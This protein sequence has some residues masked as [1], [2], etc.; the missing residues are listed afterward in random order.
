[1]TDAVKKL[2]DLVVECNQRYE[3]FGNGDT[4]A[5]TYLI[6]AAYAWIALSVESLIPELEADMAALKEQVK[7][8]NRKWIERCTR[9]RAKDAR[10]AEE[11]ER[12]AVAAALLPVAREM[13]IEMNGSGLRPDGY[14][15]CRHYGFDDCTSP[16][17][18]KART[19]RSA[20]DVHDAEA[21]DRERENICRWLESDPNWP[22]GKIAAR[23]LREMAVEEKALKGKSSR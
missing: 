17:C 15:N 12:L 6:A 3:A 9:F 14:G 22:D 2:R 16:K 21:R 10:E 18:Q 11:H 1:M 23:N 4:Q 5:E 13:H 19:D 7:I 8:T 20:L